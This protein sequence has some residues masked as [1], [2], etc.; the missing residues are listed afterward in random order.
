MPSAMRMR[1]VSF[2]GCVPR[3]RWRSSNYGSAR[4]TKYRGAAWID[5]MPSLLGS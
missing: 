3:A 4:D 2:R 1:R 5:P